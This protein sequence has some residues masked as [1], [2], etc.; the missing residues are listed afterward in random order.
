MRCHDRWF[1]GLRRIVAAAITL[2]ALSVPVASGLAASDERQSDVRRVVTRWNSHGIPYAEARA[3]G[4]RAIPELAAMLKDPAMEPHWTKVVWVLGCIGDS[5]ATAPLVDFLKRQKGEVSVDVFRATLAVLPA[6]GHVARGGDAAAL[7]TLTAFTQPD[8][9]KESGL[10]FTYARYSGPALG[11]VL[12]RTAIQGL[13]IAGTPETLGVLHSLNTS[14]LRPDW[15]DNVQ[16]AIAL[17]SRVARL[18]PARAF[19]EEDNQ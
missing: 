8:A 13:G 11:E 12:A 4:V 15:Q 16:E 9:W 5:S 6:L 2:A 19:A 17:N 10:S 7:A 14:T 1:T 18:G 3:L